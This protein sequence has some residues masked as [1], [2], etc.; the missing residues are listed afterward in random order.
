MSLLV[1]GILK[2]FNYLIG[3][4]D[5]K[6]S[7]WNLKKKNAIF[8]TEFETK[9]NYLQTTKDKE[10]LISDLSNDLYIFK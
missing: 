6:V 5:N 2:F 1:T 7:L 9:I 3:S 4:L 8:N 10:L